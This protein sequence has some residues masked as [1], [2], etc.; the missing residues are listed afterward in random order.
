MWIVIE[1]WWVESEYDELLENWM[2]CWQMID[3]CLLLIMMW[4]WDVL[5]WEM[6]WELR[7]WVVDD[8]RM[9]WAIEIVELKFVE[10]D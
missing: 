7:C 9:S 10:L 5:S 4:M 2:T 1:K 3:L 6:R 8:E